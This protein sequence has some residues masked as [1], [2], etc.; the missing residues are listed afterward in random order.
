MRMFNHH[1]MMDPDNVCIHIFVITAARRALQ[2]YHSIIL[3]I[4]ILIHAL[5]DAL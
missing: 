2:G 4:L 1:S 3:L 5:L